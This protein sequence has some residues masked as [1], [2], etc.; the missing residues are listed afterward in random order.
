MALTVII[1]TFLVVV[2]QVLILPARVRSSSRTTSTPTQL[3][4][5]TSS[6]N[7]LLLWLPLRGD[8]HLIHYVKVYICKE[9]AW[10]VGWIFSLTSRALR[11]WQGQLPGWILSASR[12]E[13][14]ERLRKQTTNNGGQDANMNTLWTGE[15]QCWFATSEINHGYSDI[16]YCSHGQQQ[17]SPPS[18]PTAWHQLQHSA[19]LGYF[20]K[21][22]GPEKRP[23]FV[24]SV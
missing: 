12:A 5:S 14:P 10:R 4:T 1:L 8:M 24:V 11:S 21:I 20:S 3:D 2:L 23:R 22:Q 6:P 9:I 7:T 17:G 19:G 16:G 18:P 15:L 13:Q